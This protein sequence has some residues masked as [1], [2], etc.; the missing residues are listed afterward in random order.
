MKKTFDVLS[1]FV[2]D[3]GWREKIIG[4][5]W[6]GFIWRKNLNRPDYHLEIV[7]KPDYC[8]LRIIS[9]SGAIQEIKCT[10]L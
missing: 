1:D 9:K 3:Q 8:I 10:A 2:E 4:P 5:D 7:E 6:S